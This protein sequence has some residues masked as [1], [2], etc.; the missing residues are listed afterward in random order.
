MSVLISKMFTKEITGESLTI[1]ADYGVKLIS[2]LNNT[3]IDG[4][5]EGQQRL[6]GIDSDPITIGQSES[7]T[8]SGWEASVIDGLVITA[9]AG[10]TLKIIA[11][12]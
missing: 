1:I 10:C 5:V 7:V 2:I 11:A 3:A 4:S 9:P 8:F 6:G 12:V